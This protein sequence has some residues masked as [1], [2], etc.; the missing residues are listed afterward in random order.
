MER[1]RR[2]ANTAERGHLAGM[3]PVSGGHAEVHSGAARLKLYVVGLETV[4]PPLHGAV[5]PSSG[6]G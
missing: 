4:A 5:P 6:T 2:A 1:V 3:N